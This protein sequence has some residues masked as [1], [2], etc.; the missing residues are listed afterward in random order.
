MS[1]CK[2]GTSWP[3]MACDVLRQSTGS[4]VFLCLSFLP[5]P[6]YLP[7][8]NIYLIVS[9]LLSLSSFRFY[10]VMALSLLFSYFSVSVSFTLI[11]FL[12]FS[13]LLS[14]NAKR[15]PHHT[16][17]ARLANSL[18][19]GEKNNVGVLGNSEMPMAQ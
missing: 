2:K 16:A 13:N 1:F 5:S 8:S 10:S 12:S 11:S 9:L 19:R 17:E 15:R 3:W 7:I 18:S 4:I 6:D 14:E